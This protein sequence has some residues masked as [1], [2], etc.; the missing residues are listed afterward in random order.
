[1]RPKYAGAKVRSITMAWLYTVR[2]RGS[3][4]RRVSA[5]ACSVSC[6][7]PRVAQLSWAGAAPAGLE[8]TRGLGA[9]GALRGSGGAALF[10]GAPLASGALPGGSGKRP[11]GC[12]T[13]AELHN[14]TMTQ[15]ETPRSMSGV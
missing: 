7:A 15:V 4:P 2:A 9:A 1:A 6:R 14:H 3:S 8:P 13:A 12:A 10:A 5:S 11:T